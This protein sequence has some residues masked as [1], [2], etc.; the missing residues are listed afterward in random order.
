MAEPTL[1]VTQPSLAWAVF[2]V[3]GGS[4]IGAVS[5]AIISYLIQRKNLSAAREQRAEDRK[6]MRRATGYS[7]LFKMIK[8]ASSVQ[9]LRDALQV[10]VEL[11]REQGRRPT[12]EVV[13]PIGPPTENI[14]F[15]AEEMALILSLDDALFN[16]MAALDDMHNNT[17]GIFNLYGQKREALTSRLGAVEE[18]GVLTTMVDRA[19][20]EWMAPRALE[21]NGIIQHMIRSSTEDTETAWGALF[22]LREVLEAK[23]DIRHRLERR[24]PAARTI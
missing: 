2:S 13:Q 7:I 6:N 23:L 1:V 12:W 4:I 14:H 8:L 15:S 19:T 22:R 21:L 11:A 16:Q 24:T 3:I 10:S 9:N 18:N 5:S 20:A 17:A